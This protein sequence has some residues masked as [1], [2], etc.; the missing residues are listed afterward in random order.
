LLIGLTIVQV[1]NDIPS[2]F[3]AARWGE[4]GNKIYVAVMV[5]DLVHKFTNT[6]EDWDQRDAVEIYLHTT[7][8]GPFAYN[9][10]QADAQ[11]YVVG[12]KTD[13]STVWSTVDEF[14]IPVEAGFSAAGSVDGD[15]LY[16]EVAMTPFKVFSKTGTGLEIS[17]LSPN[18]VIGLD[19]CAVGHNG[20]KYVGMKSE[21]TL[22]NKY[23]DY[24]SL[25]LHKLVAPLPGDAN[26]DNKVDVG[27]LGILAA[28]YG[29][30]GK[31]WSEG[32]FNYDGKVDV[33][34][35]GILA[36]NYGTHASGS[37]WAVDYAKVF[38]TSAI[39]DES[40]EAG[41]ICSELGLPLIAGL[42]LAGLMLVKLD[43]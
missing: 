31:S 1:N 2:A 23:N 11:Q 21:N 10:T 14:A 27:D 15:W 7:G 5:R 41:S 36:A 3:Y 30:T 12:F 43:E 37:D 6:Y 17:T 35:L 38:G 42:V 20:A 24:R 18:Q 33:G 8:D 25:G 29:G 34:D 40:E 4:N 26:G 13:A 16:Y 22:P 19:V 32:D 9:A 28:N 39:A